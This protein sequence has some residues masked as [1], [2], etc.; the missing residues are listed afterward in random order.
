MTRDAH[1]GPDHQAEKTTTLSEGVA[2]AQVTSNCESNRGDAA[3]QSMPGEKAAGM[4]AGGTFHASTEAL[5]RTAQMRRA[6]ARWDNEGGADGH[7]KAHEAELSGGQTEVPLTNAEL[8]Q[9]QIR[10]IALENMVT[11]LFAGAPETVAT[12]AR[13]FAEC[14]SP[15]PG[16]TAHSLTIHAAAQMLHITQ[17]SALFRE[18]CEPPTS[19]S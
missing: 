12:L 9:M 17:R 3:Q 11:A 16:H 2:I 5:D 13:E 8:V 1:S 6:I 19:A 7:E 14:I 18:Q 4:T 15:R 10:I